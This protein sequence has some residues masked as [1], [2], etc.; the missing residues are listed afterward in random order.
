MSELSESEIIESYEKL[1]IRQRQELL[2]KMEDFSMDVKRY[3]VAAIDRAVAD[4]RSRCFRIAAAVASGL[5]EQASKEDEAGESELCDVD[6]AR[7]ATA[8]EIAT[9]IA[10]DTPSQ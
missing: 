2:A 8:S 5:L 4:E 1:K 10:M 9:L 7:S 3:V 6:E